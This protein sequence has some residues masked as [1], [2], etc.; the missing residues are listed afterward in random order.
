M[1][2]RATAAERMDA[3]HKHFPKETVARMYDLYSDTSHDVRYKAMSNL[4]KRVGSEW[5]ELYPAHKAHRD[6][7]RR[8]LSEEDSKKCGDSTK[9][10]ESDDTYA[11]YRCDIASNGDIE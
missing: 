6:H 11:G 2:V 5:L 4:M 3:M 9:K 1:G 7:L 10:S 8:R